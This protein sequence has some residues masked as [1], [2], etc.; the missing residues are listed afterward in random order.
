MMKHGYIVSNIIET[1]IIPVIKN[2][3]GDGTDK[4]NYRPIDISTNHVKGAVYFNN[5]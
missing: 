5:T 1:M 3:P 2:K 4:H